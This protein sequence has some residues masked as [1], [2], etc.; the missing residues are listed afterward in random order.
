MEPCSAP[1]SSQSKISQLVSVTKFT[2]LSHFCRIVLLL[3]FFFLKQFEKP[4][5]DCSFER[6]NYK[7]KKQTGRHI[8]S[9]H[10]CP[11]CVAYVSILVDAVP[12]ECTG[13]KSRYVNVMFLFVSFFPPSHYSTF[14]FHFISPPVFTFHTL[15]SLHLHVSR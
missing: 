6:Y 1:P 10:S 14:L 4:L 2:A 8:L 9:V 3:L 7:D 11:I 5:L 12:H 15:P 13:T